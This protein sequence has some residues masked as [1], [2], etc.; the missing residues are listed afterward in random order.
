MVNKSTLTSREV[1]IGEPRIE[2]RFDTCVGDTIIGG[3]AAQ[4]TSDTRVLWT[5]I[6][7]CSRLLL[8]HSAMA[9]DSELAATVNRRI[10]AGQNALVIDNIKSMLPQHRFIELSRSI[11]KQPATFWVFVSFVLN[12]FYLRGILSRRFSAGEYMVSGRT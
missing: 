8:N 2:Q 3:R 6:M 9:R 12:R 4:L 5:D 10:Q 1:S 11:L 7:G